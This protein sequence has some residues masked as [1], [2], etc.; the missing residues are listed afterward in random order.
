LDEPSSGMDPYSQRAIWRLLKRSKAGRC[1][2]L[3][4]HSMEEAD[5]LGDRIAIMAHGHLR[6]AAR[7]ATRG[8]KQQV[9]VRRSVC[10]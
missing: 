1:I 3:T 10:L 5:A 7:S 6:A 9:P 2:L 4:T 8:P